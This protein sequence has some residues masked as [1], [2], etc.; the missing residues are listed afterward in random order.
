MFLDVTPD[1]LAQGDVLGHRSLDDVIKGL[2]IHGDSYREK[3]TAETF[4]PRV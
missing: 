1:L 2:H 3:H 4:R